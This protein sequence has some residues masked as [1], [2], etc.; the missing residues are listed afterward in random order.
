MYQRF[1]KD[2]IIKT[3]QD[4]PVITLCGARQSGKSTLLALIG[5]DIPHLTYKTF[6]EITTRSVAQ[7]NPQAFLE[8]LPRPLVLDEVQNVPELF[9]AIKYFVDLDR[10]PGQFFLTGSADILTLPK[11]SESLAGRMEIQTLWPLS[12][13]EILGK[14]ENFIDT[15]FEPNFIF[16]KT[17][18]YRPME[19]ILLQGG[20][21][22][23]L[24]R[25]ED[26]RKAWFRSYLDTLLQRDIAN[27]S[28]IEGVT[29]LPDLLSLVAA[30]VGSQINMSDVSR[31]LGLPH[32][33]LVRYLTLLKAIFLL[34]PLQSW[35]KNLS[36]RV[37]KANKIFLNDTGVLGYLL[38]ANT[39]LL[40]EN[41]RIFGALLENFV[42]MELTKQRGWNKTSTKL[43]YFQNRLNQEV[44]FVL[45][46]DE[47][48]LV[49]IEVKSTTSVNL[50]DSKGLKALKKEAGT[51]F[52]RGVVLYMG[53]DFYQFDED[54]YLVPISSLW[55]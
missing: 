52:H 3:S 17:A 9:Q 48:R 51:R 32:T 23:V 31:S 14:K 35:S 39:N 40:L 53:Q 8:S 29:F 41:R 5:Q 28:K 16:K 13:G 46:S 36:S 26:R 20:Y 7:H 15:L 47:G 38:R 55:S 12:Q 2:N 54:L 34:V 4:T 37:S 33:T 21:P 45:E 24:K 43:Y 30:R 11:I 18:L 10:K 49:G 44:D 42:F 22:D 27:L 50:N 1:I 19:E 25:E 6:D